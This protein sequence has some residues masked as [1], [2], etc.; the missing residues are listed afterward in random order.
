MET[1]ER[2][3]ETDIGGDDASRETIKAGEF[4]FVEHEACWKDSLEYQQRDCLHLH[5][6]HQAVQR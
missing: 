3:E 2:V 6:Y 5:N 1:R 4:C